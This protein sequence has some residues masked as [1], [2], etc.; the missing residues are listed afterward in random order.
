MHAASRFHHRRS[1]QRERRRGPLGIAT[2]RTA[3]ETRPG[4]SSHD[5]CSAT[6]GSLCLC[7]RSGPGS[8]NDVSKRLMAGSMKFLLS[9]ILLSALAFGQASTSAPA[10]SASAIPVDQENVRKAKTLL[11]QM[12]QAL[13]G[14]DYLNV[15]D[16]SQ[17]GRSYNFHL[18]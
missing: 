16:M 7:S 2:T 17:E 5:L 1:I 6:I 10:P 12:I 9:A 3:P 8:Y 18:G 14:N 15:E 4:G 13:G 11:D